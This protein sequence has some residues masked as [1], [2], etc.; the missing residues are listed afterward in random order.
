[1]KTIHI[2][3]ILS[4]LTIGAMAQKSP[5]QL[6]LINS[7]DIVKG[8]LSYG[9]AQD[10]Q[11]TNIRIRENNNFTTGISINR[12]MT[13]RWVVGAGLSFSNKTSGKVLDCPVCNTDTN[14]FVASGASEKE[15]LHYLSV[16]ITVGYAITQTRFRPIIKGGL[17]NNVLLTGEPTE[18]RGYLLELFAGIDLQYRATPRISALLGLQIRKATTSMFKTPVEQGSPTDK[19]IT[20]DAISLGVSYSL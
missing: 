14:D 12:T 4:L 16:P 18:G 19:T 13:D 1:M 5:W 9:S 10:N 11:I 15:Q 20:T 8:E 6:T 17:V 2:T 3:I 7:Y